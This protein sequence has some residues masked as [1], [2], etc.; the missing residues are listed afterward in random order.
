MSALPGQGF[1][2]AAVR[3]LSGTAKALACLLAIGAAIWL[4]LPRMSA[5]EHMASGRSGPV[6]LPWV[7]QE[8]TRGNHLDVDLR[9]GWLTTGRWNIIPDDH[10]TALR[11]NGQEVPLA[12]VRPGGVSDYERGFDYDL[13]PWLHHGDN[14]LQFTLDNYGGDGGI[15]LRPRL[16][17]RWLLP[18]AAFLCWL[19]LL[20]RW[21]G[22]SRGQTVVLC[23]V[24]PLLCAYIAATPWNMRQHDVTGEG[25]HLGYIIYIANHL[26]LPRPDA[27]WTFYHPPLYYAAGALVWAWAQWLG[28]P[29]AE[30][31]QFMA[32]GL[33]LVFLAASAGALRLTLRRSRPALALA[34]AALGLWPSGPIHGLAIGNDAALYA[35]AAVATWFVLRWWRGGRRR[36]LIGMAVFIALAL[37][38]KSNAIALAAAAAALVGLRML[39]RR[40]RRRLRDWLD[41]AMA[42][43]IIGGG[44]LL[45]L[46]TH[47]Y[48]YWRGVIPNWLIA[49]VGGLSPGLRVPVTIRAF[50]PL[51]IP[52]FLTSPWLDAFNDASGRGN[53]WNYLLRSA[54]TGEFH[55]DAAAQRYIALAWG[56]LLLWLLCLLLL[57]LRS[58]RWS[59]PALWRDAPW[60]VLGAAWLASLAALRI[61]APYACS[62]D[63][64]YIL[65]VLVPLI[66]AYTRRGWLARALLLTLA[67]GSVPFLMM[68]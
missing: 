7:F 13:S 8:A 5:V 31:L 52:V 39:L 57:Q 11:I 30:C 18:G 4:V 51:D 22:L 61:E 66:L 12:T 1:T 48:W 10:L 65:P 29:G 41:A 38:V 37:L 35:M 24:L 62:N 14:L 58:P 27:G 47:V 34:T 45:S 20:A 3:G 43:G 17:W 59:R 40:H 67:L 2:A 55:F 9:A 46:G 42:A 64:R 54:L 16:G 56:V 25:G 60:I 28:L 21:F 26:A 36:H 6:T 23:L 49:N 32:L 68:L 44:M 50:V 63:F 19:L 33:W 53:F 15:S